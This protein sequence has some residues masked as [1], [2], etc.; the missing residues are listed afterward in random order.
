MMLKKYKLAKT[1]FFKQK[2]IEQAGAFSNLLKTDYFYKTF[3]I[4]KR[5][6]LIWNLIDRIQLTVSQD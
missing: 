3:K 4:S 6:P 2:I 5:D 1:I